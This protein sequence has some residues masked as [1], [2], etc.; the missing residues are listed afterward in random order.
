MARRRARRPRRGGGAD[1]RPRVR[2][3]A[4]APVP[5]PDVRGGNAMRRRPSLAVLAAITAALAAGVLGT[6]GTAGAVGST[7]YVDRGN[8]SCSDT[9]SG[10]QTQ[11]FCTISAAAKKAA[12]G[13][14]VLVSSGTYSEQVSVKS[15]AAGNPIV[16]QAAPGATVTVTGGQYGFFLLKK[17]WG[18]IEG[19]NGTKKKGE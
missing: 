8:G 15:G 11:P 18:T 14:T 13:N 5:P 2:P 10:T 17:S 1:R 4:A 12:A 19:V 9:G 16:F 3:A 7:L 6:A